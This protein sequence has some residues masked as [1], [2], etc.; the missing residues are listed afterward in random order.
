MRWSEDGQLEYLGRIDQQVK[1]RGFRIELGEIE[2]QLLAQPEVREAVVVAKEGPSGLRLMAYVVPV[3][4]GLDTSVI[5]ERLAKALP[6]Y[7]LP[8]GIGVLESFPLTTSG[9]LDRRALPDAEVVHT[10]YEAPQGDIEITLAAIWWEVLGVEQI[11]RHDNF[12]ELGGDSIVSLKVVAKARE[13]GITLALKQV[14][15]HPTLASL[16]TALEPHHRVGFQDRTGQMLRLL[17][18]FEGADHVC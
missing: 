6:D 4:V 15:Q 16:A 12:F 13:R 1:I 18:E 8:A 7:M 10:V 14:F 17:D 11:G 9:K 3:A 5:R 2:S